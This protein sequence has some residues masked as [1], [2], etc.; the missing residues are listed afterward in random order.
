MFYRSAAVELGI[1]LLSFALLG[2]CVS[3]KGIVG[4]ELIR[5]DLSLIKKELISGR[6]I[7]MTDYWT[8]R[9]AYIVIPISVFGYLII[10]RIKD[11]RDANSIRYRDKG[12]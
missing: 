8:Q 9:I 4:A 10:D 6:D 3:K 1:F 2:G 11:K 7:N 5:A 12:S